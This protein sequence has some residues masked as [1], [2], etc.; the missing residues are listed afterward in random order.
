MRSIRDFCA[1]AENLLDK[2]PKSTPWSLTGDS[3]SGFNLTL[4][5]DQETRKEVK[6]LLGPEPVFES[7]PLGEEAW[8]NKNTTLTIL[9]EEDN[10]G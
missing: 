2:L 10:D 8:L 6:T 5:C 9:F 1:F 4:C 3:A 7:F